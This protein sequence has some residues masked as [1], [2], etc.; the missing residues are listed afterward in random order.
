MR[1]YASSR[2]K[3]KSFYRKSELQMFLLISGSHIG[4]PKRYTNMA[5][6]VPGDIHSSTYREKNDLVVVLA[7]YITQAWKS[8]GLIVTVMPLL[9]TWRWNCTLH[10]QLQLFTA[11]LRKKLTNLLPPSSFMISTICLNT[12]QFPL[13]GYWSWV[14]SI[15]MW[16]TISWSYGG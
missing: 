4:A 15:F 1:T 10:Q 8:K 11:L 12:S 13:V 16:L 9:N 14:T 2:V 7:C 3:R 5:S 6:P